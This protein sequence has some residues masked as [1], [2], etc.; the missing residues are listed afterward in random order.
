[1]RKTT[2]SSVILFVILGMVSSARAE[3]SNSQRCRESATGAEWQPNGCPHCQCP[4]GFK[5]SEDGNTCRAV[6]PRAPRA[7]KAAPVVVPPPEEIMIQLDPQFTSNVAN[8]KTVELKLRVTGIA[9]QKLGKGAKKYPDIMVHES[10]V[11]CLT[12]GKTI[13]DTAILSNFITDGVAQK[14]I[15]LTAFDK[16]GGEGTVTV[17]VTV[18]GVDQPSVL[19]KMGWDPAIVPKTV[20]ENTRGQNLPADRCDC[21]GV[22][23]MMEGQI[24]GKWQCV[25]KPTVVV[26]PVAAVVGKDGRDGRDGRSGVV[27]HF[28]LEL[29]FLGMMSNSFKYSG[30]VL[31]VGGAFELTQNFDL[32]TQVGIGVP[33][34]RKTD[35]NGELV[36]DE[37]GNGQKK[38]F[39]GLVEGGLRYWMNDYAGLRFGVAYIPIGI[40][41]GLKF[42]HAEIGGVAG[43]DFRIRVG[44]VVLIPGVQVFVG[45]HLKSGGSSTE[46][47]YGAMG[48]IGASFFNNNNNVKTTSAAVAESVDDEEDIDPYEDE[49]PAPK[50]ARADGR[51]IF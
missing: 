49:K 22:A 30:A 38:Y 4:A 14:A 31:A 1:M 36:I 20:C 18:G 9:K 29:K 47:A 32:Y 13:R 43:V 44:K 2:L 16:K 37:N 28:T 5:A 8:E 48:F 12:E 34:V 33:G 51:G 41:E 6:K 10:C 3:K 39:S 7:P 45:G 23:G 24:D 25:P 35:A 21:S 11:G 19:A 17:T 15:K 27:A 50:G 46:S 26:K 42:L 40:T